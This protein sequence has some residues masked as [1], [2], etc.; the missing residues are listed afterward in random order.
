MDKQQ[1]QFYNLEKIN[2]VID[3]NALQ[4]EYAEKCNNFEETLNKKQQDQFYE[5]ENLLSTLSHEQ[6][7]NLCELVVL[8]EKMYKEP[9]TN[10]FS[11]S[12]RNMLKDKYKNVNISLEDMI[13]EMM[14][15]E[16]IIRNTVTNE[17]IV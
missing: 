14:I 4:K 11:E 3:N 10:E 9:Y 8:L 1:D 12:L 2:D 17:K 16:K 7:K 13:E 6:R 5:L 15:I